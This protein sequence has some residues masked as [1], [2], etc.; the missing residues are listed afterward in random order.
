MV[1]FADTMSSM[2]T[3]E[4][5]R[6]IRMRLDMRTAKRDC[7]PIRAPLNNRFKKNVVDESTDGQPS[8]QGK[9]GFR[10]RVYKNSAPHVMF[11]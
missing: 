9:R 5:S 8:I 2:S 1:T 4:A 10:K 11:L 3:Q 6:R 7:H